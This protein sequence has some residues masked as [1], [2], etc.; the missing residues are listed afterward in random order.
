MVLPK[1]LDLVASAVASSVSYLGNS[2]PPSRKHH[3]QRDLP[4]VWDV[5]Q[6]HFSPFWPLI[7]VWRGKIWRLWHRVLFPVLTRLQM[8]PDYL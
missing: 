6:C 7:L 2:L 8:E 5:A 3:Y 1:G 4:L